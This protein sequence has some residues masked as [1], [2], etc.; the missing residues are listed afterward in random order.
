MA[1][2]M[3]S[4]VTWLKL[5]YL[6]SNCIPETLANDG[7]KDDPENVDSSD[8]YMPCTW[9]DFP[10]TRYKWCEGCH[11][12][13]VWDGMAKYSFAINGQF[14]LL[15]KPLKLLPTD[16]HP[17]DDFAL[18]AAMSLIK[19]G[20]PVYV[21]YF[22]DPVGFPQRNGP[23]RLIQAAAVL[24]FAHSQSPANPQILLLLIR[25]Y[26][27]LGAGS[28]AMRAYNRLNVKQIQGDT[29]GYMLFDRISSLHPHPVQ[30]NEKG[31]A[32]VLDPAAKLAKLQSIYRN[33]HD[34]IT[35]NCWR[36][37]EAGSY[38]SIFQLMEA[39]DKLSRSLGCAISV[40]ELRKILRLTDPNATFDKNSQGYDL[41]GKFNSMCHR[42]IC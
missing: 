31:S 21:K 15:W 16:I 39:H 12:Y 32:E 30:D 14:L 27:L 9:C 36:S 23:K 1:E 24:E 10:S 26:S 20:S 17:G 38:D 42:F 18:V 13:F 37:F 11:K 22:A 29:L 35:S 19:L 28:L 33:F 7:K 40:I 2:E 5:M 25:L 6:G 4:S 34:Q 8:E 41:L 3:T